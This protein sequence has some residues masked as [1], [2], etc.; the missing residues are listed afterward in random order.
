MKDIKLIATDLDGTLLDKNGL[1]PDYTKQTILDCIDKGILFMI[2]SGRTHETARKPAVLAGLSIIIASA[3]GARIDQTP[4]GPTIYKRLM[5]KA[6]CDSVY[7]ILDECPGK[8][9]SYIR[10]INFVRS[11]AGSDPSP[12]IV[13][14]GLPDMPLQWVF[15]EPERVRKEASENVLKFEV[16]SK[17]YAMLDSY[18]RKLE[19]IGMLVT[20]SA[21]EDIEIQPQDSSKGLAVRWM[22]QKLGLTKAQIMC[23]G[24]YTNDASMLKEAGIAI[25][26]QNGVDELKQ[27]ATHIAP[28]NTEEGEARM[29]RTLVFGEDDVWPDI[30]K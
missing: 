11:E 30:Q 1:I 21:R 3:N 8:L 26:M 6:E 28:P 29:I 18:K 17:D 13:L 15:N 2:V 10:G 22:A 12:R 27:I 5:N 9:H 20:S 24:D 7:K 14:D 19:D 4:N 25:A 16:Y 23:F